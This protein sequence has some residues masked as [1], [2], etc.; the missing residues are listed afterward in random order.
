[1]GFLIERG[2]HAYSLEDALLETISELTKVSCGLL[3]RKV[4]GPNLGLFK[5]E[6]VL[7]FEDIEK[8]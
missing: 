3:L 5:L 8:V 2:I 7:S 6:L 4:N 1:M